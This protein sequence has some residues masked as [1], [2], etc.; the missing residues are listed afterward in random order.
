MTVIDSRDNTVIVPQEAELPA[1][2]IHLRRVLLLKP[3]DQAVAELCRMLEPCRETYQLEIIRP[4]ANFTQASIERISRIKSLSMLRF[5]AVLPESQCKFEALAAISKL[6]EL[7]FEDSEIADEFVL[8]AS[9]NP[10]LQRIMING[11]PVTDEALRHLLKLESLTKLHIN[12]PELTDAAFESLSKMRTLEDLTL[13]SP[14]LTDAI[15]AP[16]AELPQLT[17][18]YISGPGDLLN[19]KGA[20]IAALSRGK[21]VD[22]LLS[23]PNLDETALGEIA[24]L[25]QLRS[26]SLRQSA[27]SDAGLKSLGRLKNLENLDLEQTNVTKAGVTALQ[28]ALPNCKIHYGK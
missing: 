6:N 13:Q 27:V 28:Q 3:D 23:A 18:L 11:C 8:A 12:S 24:T 7:H 10:R 16:I 15:W 5:Q 21:I 22:L 14:N 25:T 19:L 9:Q 20:G 1:G 4:T 26:L 17:T 2:P